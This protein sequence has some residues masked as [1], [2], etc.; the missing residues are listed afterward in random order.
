MMPRVALL[1]L[2]AL[3]TRAAVAS[4]L[5]RIRS[6]E[7]RDN[8]VSL[9]VLASAMCMRAHSCTCVQ[10]EHCSTLNIHTSNRI[11]EVSAYRLRWLGRSVASGIPRWRAVTSRL[12]QSMP[13]HNAHC[14]SKP[15]PFLQHP[16]DGGR[17]RCLCRPQPGRAPG[18]CDGDA[19]RETRTAPALCPPSTCTAWLMPRSWI[20]RSPLHELRGK[21]SASKNVSQKPPKRGRGTE[22]YAMNCV[23][24][25]GVCRRRGT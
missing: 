16:A 23:G 25:V 13:R 10:A 3:I 8:G 22:P 17:D 1:C 11:R 9:K 7:R 19:R 24:A 2:A 14:C 18:P 20:A 21:S 12:A 6:M 5:P 15:A 4:Q